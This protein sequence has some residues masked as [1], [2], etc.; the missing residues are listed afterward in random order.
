MNPFE[1]P[2]EHFLARKDVL[3]W[4]IEDRSLAMAKFAHETY[5]HRDILID[6]WNFCCYDLIDAPT[7]RLDHLTKVGYFPWAEASKELDQALS[8]TMIGHYK[9]AYDS[10]RRAFELVVTGS[11][12]V[13]DDIERAKAIAWIKSKRG[14][15]N[16][17]RAVRYLLKDQT[18]KTC[19]DECKWETYMLELYWHLCD[20]VHVS[21]TR[22][23][24]DAIAPSFSS[25]N[26]IH[27]LGFHEDSCR[28]A[29][30]AFIQTVRAIACTVALSNPVLLVGFDLDVKFGLN[31][32]SSGF[33]YPGQAELLRRLI[34]E[35]FQPF[36][37]R[38]ADTDEKVQ[39]LTAWFNSLPDIT[40]EQIARQARTIFP[41]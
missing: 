36:M 4:G 34:V 26:G 33:F 17:K 12:F 24:L 30:D 2:E 27:S 32:P 28:N 18:F 41:T 10:L 31:P 21:G 25:I 1:L 9:N 19:N 22:N 35:Q 14:T 23:S 5:E 37:K 8:L 6:A 3:L 29:L 13:L 40:T 38:L 20:V 16:F 15:P 7:A 11:Y 39:S